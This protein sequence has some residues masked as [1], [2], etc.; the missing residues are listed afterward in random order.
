[1]VIAHLARSVPVGRTHRLSEG[2][3]QEHVAAQVV[4]VRM[5]ECGGQE[6]PP[7]RLLTPEVQVR[8]PRDVQQFVGRKDGEVERQ[9]DENAV[10]E[11][12]LH[13]R[14]KSGSARWWRRLLAWE[15][16]QCWGRGVKGFGA[17]DLL[18]V[19]PT[20]PW[21]VV[22]PVAVTVLWQPVCA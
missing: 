4:E 10:P 8:H 13:G 3:E 16:A 14:R 18:R 21:C 15:R 17:L 19:Q 5:T 22:F 12:L 20:Q 11:R 1:M 6:L 7:A 9:E 2:P